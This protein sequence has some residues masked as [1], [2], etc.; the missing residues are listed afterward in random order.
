MSTITAEV[1]GLLCR[2][3][4]T[5]VE[6]IELLL[7]LSGVMLFVALVAGLITLA[8][9]PIVLRVGQTR[10]PASIVQVALFAGSLPMLVI[11]LQYFLES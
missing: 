10:P 2:W 3:Y 8:L 5:L 1:I 4:T 11:G 6:P 7:V 9:I